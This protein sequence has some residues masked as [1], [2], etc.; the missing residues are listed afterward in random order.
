LRCIRGLTVA[1]GRASGAKPNL[2]LKR[3][4]LGER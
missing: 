3:E 1:E 2:M 4:F